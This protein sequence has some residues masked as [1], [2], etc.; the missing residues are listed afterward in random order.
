MRRWN[1]WG[2]DSVGYPLP[3]AAERY[4]TQTLGLRVS[5]QDAVFEDVLTSL[6]PTR[7]PSNSL[8]NRK[9]D[10][11]L[12]HARGQSLPDWIAMR[13][14]MPGTVPD[15]VA[16]PE[17]A[18]QVRSLLKYA[19]EHHTQLIPYGGGTS[20][21]G[22]INPLPKYGPALTV[23]MRRLN[24]LLKV[25]EDSHLATFEAGASGPEI[26]HQLNQHGFTLGHYPQSWEY[27]TLGGWIATRS[28]GQQSFCYGR[29]EDL[30]RG[31]SL[32]TPN[33]ILSIPVNPASA[34]GPDLRQLVL[35]SGG[36]MGLITHA[37]LRVRALPQ[38]EQFLGAFFPDWDSGMAAARVIGQQRVRLSML[39]LSDAQ[40][41][42]TLLALTGRDRLLRVAEWGLRGLG[43]GPKRCLMIYALTGAPADTRLT[44][45]HA[46]GIFRYH[47]GLPTGTYIGRAWKKS[48]F[49]SPYMRNT[50]WEMGVAL[51]T[52]ETAVSW[53]MFEVLRSNVLS[54]IQRTFEDHDVAVAARD[55]LALGLTESIV[56][57]DCDVHQ[58]DGT[59]AIFARDPR[60]FTFS[61]HGAGNFPFRKVA[62]D[63]DI[64][65][66]DGTK[67]DEYLQALLV[68]LEGAL[69][70]SRPSFAIYLAGADPYH[71]DT[72]GRLALT[73]AGLSERD[74]MVFTA[75]RQH[76]LPVAVVMS[77]GYASEIDDIVDIHLETLRRAAEI[78]D[79]VK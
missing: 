76:E 78:S 20:V 21:V 16:F 2:D 7:L 53:T 64:A 41:T 25:D 72:F 36:R 71:A 22:H 75:C 48:R 79:Y 43:H 27:S 15:G 10:V 57:L 54:A 62:S 18:R 58:G 42:E 50:L 37:T 39:R 49:R 38:E 40:E 17:S 59:A 70:R 77:G 60:V 4:L 8:V 5:D 45:S 13:A 9:P 47:G 6:P 11:R 63:M 1:G 24:R 34:A 26:E 52:L 74:R 66:A 51:D 3:E 61:V 68:G 30:F 12:R 31:A 35:G 28:S 65:L 67:D 69:E 19:R 32:E 56:I 23:S 73:K 29:I 14:G 33:G 44:R 46:H 55:L